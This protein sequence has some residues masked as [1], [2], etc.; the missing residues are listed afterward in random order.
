MNKFKIGDIVKISKCSG[1][2]GCGK[3]SNNPEDTPGKIIIAHGDGDLNIRVEW[4]N[5][6]SNCYNETDLE[7]VKP[8]VI[9]DE[10]YY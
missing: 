7:L 2:Y 10:F 4:V 3:S 9:Q 5:G 8:R 6:T 1:Y